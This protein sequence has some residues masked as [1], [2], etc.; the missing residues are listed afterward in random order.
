MADQCVRT[1]RH[2]V[3]DDVGVSRAVSCSDMVAARPSR[4]SRTMEGP[5]P[6]CKPGTDVRRAHM[7]LAIKTARESCLAHVCDEEEGA[8]LSCAERHQALVVGIPRK[9]CPA[10][11]RQLLQGRR[12]T[13]RRQNRQQAP[14]GVLFHLLL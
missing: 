5:P 10:S 14:L 11:P 3:G 9:A 7:Y 4:G 1:G 8:I 12:I 13:C 2:S 6:S